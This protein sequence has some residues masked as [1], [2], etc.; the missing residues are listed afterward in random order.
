MLVYNYTNQNTSSNILKEYCRNPTPQVKISFK[1]KDFYLYVHNQLIK[2]N[3]GGFI[4]YFPDYITQA[5]V[6]SKTFYEHQLLEHIL[7]N[8]PNHK[9]IVEV[10]ANIGNHVVFYEHFL[11]KENILA[12]EPEPNN[13]KLLCKNISFNTTFAYQLA[14]G[15][16]YNKVNMIKRIDNNSG[17]FITTNGNNVDMIPLDSL[18]LQNVTLMKIDTEGT[19]LQVIKGAKETIRK[20][21]PLI[22]AEFEHGENVNSYLYELGYVETAEF[23]WN[24]IKTSEFTC[25]N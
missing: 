13:Y 24:N 8:H 17:S 12:F 20:C 2:R 23:Y 7:N 22:Y 1:E 19:E 18:N 9:T 4:A 5:L 6:S 10:G 14:L 25:L 3:T 11:N 21:K 15:E 16:N